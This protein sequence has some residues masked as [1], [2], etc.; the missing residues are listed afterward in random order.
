MQEQ[1][2]QKT[3]ALSIKTAKIS[4][5]ALQAAMRQFLKM[6]RKQRDKHPRCGAVLQLA[7]KKQTADC[8]RNVDRPQGSVAPLTE[9]SDETSS[10]MQFLS[11]DRE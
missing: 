2:T 1:V 11:A 7:D 8:R 9:R 6:Y 5:T 10:V 3:M 4:G